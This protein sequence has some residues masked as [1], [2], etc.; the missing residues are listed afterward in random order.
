MSDSQRLYTG[1]GVQPYLRVQETQR[2]W[3]ESLLTNVSVP[4][5]HLSF[6]E[7]RFIALVN[8]RQ[9]EQRFPQWMGLET[10]RK[11]H[12]DETRFWRCGTWSS[13]GATVYLW[14]Y[15]LSGTSVKIWNEHRQF[16]QV[17]FAF[18]MGRRDLRW[19]EDIAR[20]RS[21]TLPT[22]QLLF[23]QKSVFI[24]QSGSWAKKDR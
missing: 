9:D 17:I 16:P 8:W 14:T 21:H 4:I 3:K 19:S 12:F 11:A 24:A 5:K 22:K 1:N 20:K 23:I 18:Q 13:L 2:P 15:L 10:D 6:F 7:Q